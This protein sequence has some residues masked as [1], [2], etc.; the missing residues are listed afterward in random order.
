MT[1]EEILEIVTSGAHPDIRMS[2]NLLNGLFIQRLA[3]VS[4]KLDV[5]E[6]SEFISIAV[7]LYQRGFTEFRAD[8][9]TKTLMHRLQGKMDKGAV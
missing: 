1:E 5:D 8:M 6:I 9:E 4:D 7:V 2:L 3:A